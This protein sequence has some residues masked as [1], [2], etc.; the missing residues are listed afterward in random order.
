MRPSSQQTLQIALVLLAGA[1]MLSGALPAGA[2][3]IPEQIVPQECTLGAIRSGSSGCTVC[4]LGVVA[5]NITQFLMFAVALPA[6][7]LLVAI[8]GIT[9]LVS[10]GSETTIKRGKQTLT[11]AI[12]GL[13]IIF[14]AWLGVDTIIKILTLGQESFRGAL[15][16]WHQLPVGSCGIR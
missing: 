3:I 16:P 10:G 9:L 11:Y 7:A 8:G 4:H 2:A 6:A 12:T 1:A 13:L 15:G 14:L 5:I